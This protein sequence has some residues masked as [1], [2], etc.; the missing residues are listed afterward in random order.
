[1]TQ[2]EIPP[3][4]TYEDVIALFKEWD[5]THILSGSWHPDTEREDAEETE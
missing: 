2:E 5:Y 1:L 3:A 4:L